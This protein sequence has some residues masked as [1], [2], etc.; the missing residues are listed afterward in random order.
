[1]NHMTTAQG[2]QH[3][4]LWSV[5]V[6]PIVIEHDLVVLEGIAHEVFEGFHALARGGLE[7]GGLL[8]G[9]CEDGRLRI[10]GFEPVSCEHALGP[11]FKLSG[12]D[13]HALERQLQLHAAHSS[14]L[15]RVVVGWYHSHTRTELAFSAEDTDLHDQFFPEPW[16]V[17]LVLRPQPD[18][19]IQARF[20]FREPDG[21][22]EHTLVPYAPFSVGFPGGAPRTPRPAVQPAPTR[23]V[24]EEALRGPSPV[25]TPPAAPVR[26]DITLRTAPPNPTPQPRQPPSRPGKLVLALLAAVIVLALGAVAYMRFSLGFAT[27]QPAY[28]RVDVVNRKGVL[29]AAWDPAA[30]AS[31]ESA[32]L[33]IRDGT[34]RQQVALSRTALT[35]GRYQYR[36]KSDVIMFSL[37][38]ARVDGSSVKGGTTYIASQ[39]APAASGLAAAPL[40][41]PAA[42]AKEPVIPD[43]RFTV[44]TPLPAPGAGKPAPKPAE[45]VAVARTIPPAPK[46]TEPPHVSPQQSPAPPVQAPR[47]NPAPANA[48]ERTRPTQ[49]PATQPTPPVSAPVETAQLPRQMP[50]AVQNAP[51]SEPKPQA[52]P[53]ITVAPPRNVEPAPEPVR[54]PSPPALQLEGRW[55][56]QPGA[57]S[58]SPAVPQSLSIRMTQDGSGMV[59]G[60]VEARYKQRSKTEHISFSFA[61]RLLNGVARFPWSASDGRRGDIEFIRIPNSPDAVEVVWYGTDLKQPFDEIV[62]RGR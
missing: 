22:G 16:H 40:S 53:P 23:H 8:L 33:E 34:V 43:T 19:S 20:F 13:R 50:P 44:V 10:T 18:L 48:A 28:L 54:P 46:N 45:P 14:D 37:R 25:S 26:W 60:S 41:E 57:A 7:V 62:R 59:Q 31:A 21:S 61:G 9:A 6:C 51:A 1:M 58:R 2:T 35:A 5:P 3:F 55:T 15:D 47:N 39:R 42:G 32:I 49:Q 30:M 4:G 29:E 12:N 11:S 52:A 24:R 38:V 56:L 27:R 17:A 36:P